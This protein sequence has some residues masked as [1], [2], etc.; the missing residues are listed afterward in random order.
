MGMSERE[1]G[2]GR[3]PHVATRDRTAAASGPVSTI[4]TLGDELDKAHLKWRFYTSKYF[5]GTSGLWSG[6][7]AVKHVIDGPDWKNVITPQSRFLKDV[8]A[9]TLGAFTWITPSCPDSDHP[10]CGGGFGPSWVAS[11]VNAVGESKFWDSTAIFVQ[12]D[13]WGGFYDPVPPPFEDYDG[14]G[15]RV[16]LV[17]ISPYAKQNYVSHV[18]YETASVL[19]YAEDLFGLAQLSV[20]DARAKSPAKDCFDFNQKPTQVRS[21]QG[22][23]RPRLLPESTRRFAHSGQRSMNRLATIGAALVLASCAHQGALPYMQGDAAV[24]ALNRDRCG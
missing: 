15:F 24:R 14:N 16:P 22:A 11:V 12:W 2:H 1:D 3:Y 18:H 8:K 9:G 17:V 4:T 21:D 23:R 20:A 5:H 13:D 19:R 6:Y 10:S 7:Q